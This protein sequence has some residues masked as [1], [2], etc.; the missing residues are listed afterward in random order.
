MM[1]FDIK[2]EVKGAQFGIRYADQ[3]VF[4]PSRPMGNVA[5]SLIESVLSAAFVG[6][7][8]EV[9][10]VIPKCQSWL[11]GAIEHRESL[12]PVVEFHMSRLYEALAISR[13][14]LDDTI[15]QLSWRLALQEEHVAALAEGV[16]SPR[17]R[18]SVRLDDV[19]PAAL[20]AG[21]SSLAV[22]EY[23][24][25]LGSGAAKVGSAV[26]PRKFGY[27]I[28]LA[29]DIL[30]NDRDGLFTWGKKVLHDSLD[31]WLAHGQYMTAAKWV[32]VTYG[33][34]G[35]YSNA[36]VALKQSVLDIES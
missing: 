14:L 24:A 10:H 15:D 16:Y 34:I 35:G 4:D 9:R 3:V 25:A 5:R 22:S 18:K 29:G 8:A 1:K 12:G 28:A 6:M 11:E 27:T 7:F 33:M 23:Q 30:Q 31:G 21:E 2:K 20:L 19:V 32:C 36:A 17:D 13:W 26:K